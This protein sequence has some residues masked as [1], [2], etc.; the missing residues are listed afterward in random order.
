[1][2]APPS[3][4]SSAAIAQLVLSNGQQLPAQSGMIFGRDPD[5]SSVYVNDDRMSRAHARLEEHNGK[6][7]L[8]DLG[9]SNG[10][11]INGQAITATTVIHLGDQIQMG[12]T[13]MT[14][15][16]PGQAPALPL[17]Q[18]H[19]PS[20]ASGMA[21]APP[22]GG[23]LTWPK[24]P[25]TEGMVQQVDRSSMKREDLVQRGCLAVFLGMIAAPLAF[26]PFMQGSDVN[27]IDIRL[28]DAH[29]GVIVDIKVVGDLV[30]NISLGD[31]IAAWGN[32]PKGVILMRQA[33]NYTTGHE[34]TV[35]K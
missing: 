12:E 17:P 2:P 34:I 6:W 5:H 18:W 1:M 9:S 32:A 29:T 22:K 25:A 33:Y 16:V 31:T 35:R 20:I 11:Y 13:R 14:L 27:V 10:T 15:Q 21:V 3:L 4:S 30:G 19:D 26:L 24:T 23:W 28:L 7:L 8:T